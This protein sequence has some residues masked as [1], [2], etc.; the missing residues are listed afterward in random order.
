[1]SGFPSLPPLSNT[2]VFNPRLQPSSSAL[3]FRP[4]SFPFVFPLC[5]TP[6]SLTLVLH[7]R[8]YGVAGL[9]RRRGKTKGRNFCRL[10]VCCPCLASSSV[11]RFSDERQ[12]G[13]DK[14]E[15]QGGK[16]RG[17]DKGERR[18]RKTRE[19]DK[20]EDKGERRGGKMMGRKTRMNQIHPPRMQCETAFSR[21]I[22][23][24]RASRWSVMFLSEV[25][26]S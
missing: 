4:S 16:T 15:R 25:N 20:G 12:R 5:L 1:M 26:K 13:K 10:L 2:F 22:L 11:R 3:V 9:F 6:L 17:K 21:G 19:K 23:Q 24:A 7:L 8:L 14:G 18:G